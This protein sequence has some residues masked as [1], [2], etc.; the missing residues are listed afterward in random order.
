MR[1]GNPQANRRG[2]AACN[3]RPQW[4]QSCRLSNARSLQWRQRTFFG[5]TLIFSPHSGQTVN[6][7]GVCAPQFGQ[8]CR[9]LG[10]VTVGAAGK[11]K[12]PNPLVLARCIAGSSAFPGKL[13]IL[14]L[15]GKT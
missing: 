4:G 5:L 3:S 11:G 14:Y 15:F 7:G 8:R 10:R 12:L 9:V 13:I 6:P 1:A 2:G